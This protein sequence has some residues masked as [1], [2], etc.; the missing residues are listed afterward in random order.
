M[1]AAS[2]SSFNR[3]RKLNIVGTWKEEKGDEGREDAHV[4]AY[5]SQHC[6]RRR[7]VHCLNDCIAQIGSNGSFDE[8]AKDL[9]QKV[10]YAKVFPP[11]LPARVRK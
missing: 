5:A 4:G 7:N 2:L 6:R 1:A 8:V 3:R 10:E 9:I 11:V